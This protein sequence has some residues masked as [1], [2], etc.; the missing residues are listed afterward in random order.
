MNGPPCR[1]CN[2]P[3]EAEFVDIGVGY[4]QVTGGRCWDCC[5][6][7]RGP[8]LNGGLISE[9]E[10]VTMWSAPAEDYPEFS[11]FNPEPSPHPW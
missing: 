3:T 8:Y 9:V 2:Q 7:E 6:D 4:E 1:W 10:W 11:P 5:A